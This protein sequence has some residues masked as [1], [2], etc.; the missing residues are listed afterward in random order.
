MVGGSSLNGTPSRFAGNRLYVACSNPLRRPSRPSHRGW[1]TIAPR[2]RTPTAPPGRSAHRRKVDH[3]EVAA[4]ALGNV[5]RSPNP[6]HYPTHLAPHASTPS[7]HART[8]RSHPTR[9]PVPPLRPRIDRPRAPVARETKTSP[10]TTIP[11]SLVTGPG[12]T[13]TSP[14][15]VVQPVDPMGRTGPVPR[16]PRTG[17]VVAQ[18]ASLG[19]TGRFSG[20]TSRLSAHTRRPLDRTVTRSA[21]PCDP[22][23]EGARPAFIA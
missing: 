16:S 4:E 7:S 6:R 22:P 20:T 17:P 1:I 14:S 13:P 3:Q 11:R 10:T 15:P 12:I 19:R 23:R 2:S 21:R 18:D 5:P 9:P 8:P